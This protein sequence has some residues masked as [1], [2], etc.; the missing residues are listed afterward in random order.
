MS[1]TTTTMN[2]E[3]LRSFSVACFEASG[4]TTADA[5]AAADVLM[6]ASL[7]G[8]DT[9]GIRNLKGYYIDSAAGVGCPA[10]PHRLLGSTF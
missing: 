8:V 9:H 5:Q 4:V 6:W 2:H 10:G 3:A 7:R 1:T